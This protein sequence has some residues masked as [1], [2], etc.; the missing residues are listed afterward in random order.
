MLRTIYFNSV[1]VVYYTGF[2]PIKFI[3][4]ETQLHFDSFMVVKE[5][6]T[7]MWMMLVLLSGYYLRKRAVEMQFNAKMCGKWIRVPKP[8]KTGAMPI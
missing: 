8:N 1:E 7:C 3:R 4:T 2:L 5:T 6:L